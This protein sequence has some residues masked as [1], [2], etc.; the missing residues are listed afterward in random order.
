MKILEGWDGSWCWQEYFSYS[1]EHVCNH[2][3]V[4][5]S[6]I[7]SNNTVIYKVPFSKQNLVCV[8]CTD[9]KHIQRCKT[10]GVKKLRL[11]VFFETDFWDPV[12][13]LPAFLI[14]LSSDSPCPGVLDIT[15]GASVINSQKAS[16]KHGGSC[17]DYAFAVLNLHP[18]TFIQ[19]QQTL[20]LFS[21]PAPPPPV[22]PTSHSIMWCDWCFRAWYHVHKRLGVNILIKTSISF[23][24]VWMPAVVSITTIITVAIFNKCL[25]CAKQYVR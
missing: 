16:C 23:H 5:G 25:L 3:L 8:D 24:N 12:S 7:R 11:S 1:C 22:S 9:Y 6:L 17:R 2:K 21:L 4:L 20:S 18:P 15:A 10:S 13:H 14:A 19:D